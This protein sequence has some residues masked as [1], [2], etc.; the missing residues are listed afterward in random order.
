MPAYALSSR[1]LL[2]GAA[3]ACALVLGAAACGGSGDDGA[4]QKQVTAPT[5]SPTPTPPARGTP[6]A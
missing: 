2:R 6:T 5:G 1:H 3:L 4:A